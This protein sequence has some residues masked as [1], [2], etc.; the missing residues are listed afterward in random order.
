V[1][2][3]TLCVSQV[4]FQEKKIFSIRETFGDGRDL[5]D[6]FWGSSASYK[7]FL[8]LFYL[9]P[10]QSILE[11]RIRQQYDTATISFEW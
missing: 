6:Y 1:Q 3:Y 7:P 2:D 9:G 8:L 10:T 4:F 5:G 11:V